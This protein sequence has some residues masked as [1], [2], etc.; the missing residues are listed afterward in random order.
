MNMKE[1]EGKTVS[2]GKT[3][4]TVKNEQGKTCGVVRDAIRFNLLP[5]RQAFDLWAKVKNIPA[6]DQSGLIL[7]NGNLYYMV[8]TKVIDYYHNLEKR[9]ETTPEEDKR[10]FDTDMK[11]YRK[12]LETISGCEQDG[13]TVIKCRII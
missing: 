2:I 8:N 11:S 13:I 1:I 9:L 4:I 10:F 3:S 6:I 7:N 5:T 12:L